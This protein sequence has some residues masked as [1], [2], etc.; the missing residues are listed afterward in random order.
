M[1]GA[2]LQ[3]NLDF[4]CRCLELYANEIS[5]TIFRRLHWHIEFGR[6]PNSIIPSGAVDAL[7]ISSFDQF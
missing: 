6:G 1:K 3:F 7:G 2:K 4:R 5:L